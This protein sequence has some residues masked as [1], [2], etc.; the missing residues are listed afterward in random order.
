MC[1][2]VKD[3]SR[4][5]CEQ[6]QQLRL[7]TG[8][9]DLDIVC[10]DHHINV[11]KVVMAAS[12]K[13]FKDQLCKQNV[14]APVILRLEDFGLEL[15][16][17]AVSYI[18][19][20]VYRGEVNI[21]GEKLTEVCAAAHSLGVVGLEHLPVPA[22]TQRPSLINKDH[23]Q[24]ADESELRRD[25][26]NIYNSFSGNNSNQS[27]AIN[28]FSMDINNINPFF[29]NNN[30]IPNEDI[31]LLQAD[32]ANRNINNDPDIIPI[33]FGDNSVISH[34]SDMSVS[35]QSRLYQPNT[36]VSTIHSHTLNPNDKMNL[37][38]SDSSPSHVTSD[39]YRIIPEMLSDGA[40]HEETIDSCLSLFPG[41][42]GH[43]SDVQDLSPSPSKSHDTGHGV[44][45]PVHHNSNRHHQ[46]KNIANLQQSPVNTDVG[47]P[48]QSSSG[49]ASLQVQTL[50]WQKT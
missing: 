24:I 41:P 50:Y 10:E 21:P 5:L 48:S 38:V 37:I 19:E 6:L 12:S 18:I 30:P 22:E 49:P 31:I 14:Q 45:T 32:E 29:M 43:A 4:V 47:V 20:F 1:I 9:V 35:H 15:K 25:M 36:G 7:Q 27:S 26:N 17:D 16:R 46:G 44:K 13:F 39:Q 3:H 23:L 28:K 33:S 8:L 40:F 42:S 34:N 11:H 2:L